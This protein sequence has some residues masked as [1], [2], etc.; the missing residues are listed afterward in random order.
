MV[1]FLE[2]RSQIHGRIKVHNSPK[3]TLIISIFLI[4]MQTAAIPHQIF[5]VSSRSSKVPTIKVLIKRS[6][7]K[8]FI[9]GT[10]LKRT[11]HFNDTTQTFFGRKSIKFNCDYLI[12][13]INFKKPQLLASLTSKTGL[14]TVGKNTQEKRYRGG[15]HVVTGLD[16]KSC[17][18][19]SE[20]SLEDYL[21]SL[22]SKE[23]NA[24]WP[25]EALKAQ[26][27]AART[28]A[29]HKMESGQ[30]SHHA[31]FDTHY[32]LESSEKHQVSGSYFDATKATIKATRDTTGHI[33]VDA[34]GKMS[35]LFFYGNVVIE[36]FYIIIT[37]LIFIFYLFQHT[38]DTFLSCVLNMFIWEPVATSTEPARDPLNLIFN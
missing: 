6:L 4:C 16:N 1:L 8:V 29:L 2:N 17:D 25:L 3:F 32:D 35:P 10:D 36:T 26:A 20:S 18:V 15:L 5:G 21:S 27:V 38:D 37:T 9:S 31:G 19:V 11:F 22:L 12:G 33:L 24:S 13:K 30:V 34:K 28:Y 23:M 7:K 14:I